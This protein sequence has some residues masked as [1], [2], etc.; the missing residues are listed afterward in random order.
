MFDFNLLLN[1]S[2]S[3]IVVDSL[4]EI[5][6]MIYPH[7]IFYLAYFRISLFGFKRNAMQRI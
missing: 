6:I 3:R 5:G 1:I 7:L 4:F 2:N